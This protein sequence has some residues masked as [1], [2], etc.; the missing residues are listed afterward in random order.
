MNIIQLTLISNYHK[1]ELF[2]VGDADDFNLWYRKWLVMMTRIKKKKKKNRRG[3]YPNV[4]TIYF[5]TSKRI[6]QLDKA[7]KK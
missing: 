1:D 5:M 7:S 3:K 2:V 6:L 4:L